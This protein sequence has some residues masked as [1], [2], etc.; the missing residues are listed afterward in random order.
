MPRNFP[1]S[2]ENVPLEDIRIGGLGLAAELV[3]KKKFGE[4]KQVLE[5]VLELSP[6]DVE[7]MSLLANI[8]II[9][10][11]FKKAEEWLDKVLVIKPDYPQALYNKGAAYHKKGEFEKAIEMYE[12]AIEQYPED[13][14]ED[15]ADAYQN[16]GCSLWEARRREEALEAWEASLEYNPKQKYAKRNLKEFTNEYGLPKSSVGMDDFWAFMDFKQREYFSVKGKDSFNDTD[17]FNVVLGKIRDAWN[18]QIAQKYGRKLDRMKTKE[19]I[20]LF[21]KIKVFT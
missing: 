16:L 4:A 15:I 10:G 8:Y 21:S 12:K 3:M 11:N 1:K 2:I 17:E 9:E 18:T 19:K 6:N 7:I 5:K 14:K 13:A 20:K